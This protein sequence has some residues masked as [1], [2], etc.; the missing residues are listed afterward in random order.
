MFLHFFVITAVD[1]EQFIV[2][3]KADL[4][5][6]LSKRKKPR[7]TRERVSDFGKSKH[8]KR[9]TIFNRLRN[10][11]L[12]DL[13]DNMIDEDDFEIIEQLSFD[14]QLEQRFIELQQKRQLTFI[15]MIELRYIGTLLDPELQNHEQISQLQDYILNTIV[16]LQQHEIREAQNYLEKL[17]EL[18]RFL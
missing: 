14:E 13:E 12:E 7:K 18:S 9:Q 5:E 15:E 8:Q 2:H 10:L 6:K 16:Q 3:A 11:D 17:T 4:A 1:K